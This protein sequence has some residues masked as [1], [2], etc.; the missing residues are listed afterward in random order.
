MNVTPRQAL[1]FVDNVLG[2]RVLAT[3]IIATREEHA[4][5]QQAIQGIEME[6]VQSEARIQK[7]AELEKEIK[8]LNR[9]LP[10]KKKK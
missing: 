3:K 6:L 4:Q 1:Q 7:I 5:I 10:K 2:S 9:K 8:K